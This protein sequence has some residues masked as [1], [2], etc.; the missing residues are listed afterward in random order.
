[1]EFTY[2]VFESQEVGSNKLL[3]T[4]NG[5]PTSCRHTS[6][7]RRHHDNVLKALNFQ[8][9]RIDCRARCRR[10]FKNTISLYFCAKLKQA[11]SGRQ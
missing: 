6:R 4:K 7:Q 3:C 2:F 1:M 5:T 10:S 11:E 8:R 9:W